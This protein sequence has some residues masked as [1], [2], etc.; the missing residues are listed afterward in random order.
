MWLFFFFLVLLSRTGLLRD[1]GKLFQ[2]NKP[3]LMDIL[4]ASWATQ[5]MEWCYDFPAFILDFISIYESL[6]WSVGEEKT[7]QKNS[8]SHRKRKITGQALP[9][10]FFTIF[11]NTG[12]FC[13]SV[14]KSPIHPTQLYLKLGLNNYVHIWYSNNNVNYPLV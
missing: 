8:L 6:L 10:G 1:E 3:E 5:S 11:L 7:T 9:S 14:N 12:F 2:S 13:V 4:P